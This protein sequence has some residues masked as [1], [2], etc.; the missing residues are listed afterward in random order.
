MKA[1]SPSNAAGCRACMLFLAGG[2]TTFFT[3]A[4]DNPSALQ[5]RGV[6]PVTGNVLCFTHGDTASALI[7]GAV[8]CSC[9][10]YTWGHSKR[11]GWQELKAA[12]LCF[13]HGDTA[14]TELTVHEGSAVKSGKKYVIR[15]DVL[16]TF[17]PSPSYA[18]PVLDKVLPLL[19]PGLS[20]QVH[21]YKFRRGR[22]KVTSLYPPTRAAERKHSGL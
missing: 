19:N 20:W 6:K 4:P 13:R 14:S 16:Y 17:S 15:T 11:P 1:P 22:G 12:A 3:P 10:L 2:Y 5:A 8:S 21:L 7:S 9:A 18:G